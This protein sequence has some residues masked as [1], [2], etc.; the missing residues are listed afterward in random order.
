MNPGRILGIIMGLL[1]LVAVFVL[2]FSSLPGSLSLSG[3]VTPLWSDL[4]N[5]QQN[6]TQ[7]EITSAYI[8]IVSL[9]LLI[10]AGIVGFFPLGCGVIGIIAMALLTVGPM[11]VYPGSDLSFAGYGIGYYVAWIASVI[12]L[13]ASLWKA[14]VDKAEK[15]S[16]VNVSVASPVTVSVAPPPPPPPP[17]GVVVSP[18]ITVTQTQTV[19]EGRP[20]RPEDEPQPK[21]VEQPQPKPGEITPEDVVRTIDTLKQKQVAGTISDEQLREELGKLMFTD[22]S[23]KFWTIDFRTGNWVW[24]DGAKWIAGTPPATLKSASGAA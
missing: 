23:G 14:K 19:Q 4:S 21:P 24:H 12:A 20:P 16:Q 7:A 3:Y 5:I 11:M 18:T 10:I 15:A 2:P 13:A 1:I 6:G 22:S 17:P 8:F 9:L